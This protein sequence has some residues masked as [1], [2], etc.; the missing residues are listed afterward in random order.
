MVRQVG[1]VADSSAAVGKV[2]G[3]FD[4]GEERR[5]ASKEMAWHCLGRR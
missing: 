3:C 4:G 1:Q 5:Y 2:D